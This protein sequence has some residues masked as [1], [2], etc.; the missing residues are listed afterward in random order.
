MVSVNTQTRKYEI[1]FILNPEITDK[2]IENLVGLV[3]KEIN[4]LNGAIAKTDNWGL[5]KLSIKIFLSSVYN[6]KNV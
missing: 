5:K 6:I 1:V 3:S 4:D 2:E